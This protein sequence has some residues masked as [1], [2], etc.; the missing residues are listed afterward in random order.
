MNQEEPRFARE[1]STSG[2]KS[3]HT[4]E[5]SEHFSPE[6]LQIHCSFCIITLVYIMKLCQV[7]GPQ[8]YSGGL[9]FGTFLSTRDP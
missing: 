7:T 3:D 8:I 2:I 6:P 5:I 1:E 9:K 4:T